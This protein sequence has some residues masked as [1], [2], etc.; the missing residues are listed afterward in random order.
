M[1]ILAKETPSL[2]TR[3]WER[4]KSSIGILSVVQ[5]LAKA[6]SKDMLATRTKQIVL[7]QRQHE[8]HIIKCN[9]TTM[10]H[11]ESRLKSPFTYV[12]F[13]RQLFS[14]PNAQYRRQREKS[15]AN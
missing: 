10:V 1:E 7:L 2:P 13:H 15:G 11:D 4:W 5:G 9:Y 14:L 3:D 12:F 6:V 8:K